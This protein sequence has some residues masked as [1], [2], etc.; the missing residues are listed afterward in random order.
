MFGED[1]KATFKAMKGIAKSL[2]VK[3]H[4]CHIKEGGKIKYE[5][6][7]ERKKFARLM[8]TN[9]V[10]S[11]ATKGQVK[12]EIAEADHKTLVNAVYQV[13]DDSAAI[14]LTVAKEGKEYTKSI[15]LPAKDASISCMT[16]HGGKVHFMTEEAGK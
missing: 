9:L 13:G 10:D 2:G 7:T 5:A 16:C 1:K 8:K 14:Q 4:H 12:V 3:C 11:L 6:D 15:P